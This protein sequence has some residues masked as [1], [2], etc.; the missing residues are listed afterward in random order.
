VVCTL[1]SAVLMLI[2]IAVKSNGSVL[3]FELMD[4][5]TVISF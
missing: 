2:D 4:V 5:F 1:L 3:D